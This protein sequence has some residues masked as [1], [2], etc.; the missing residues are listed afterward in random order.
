MADA[1]GQ[2]LVVINLNQQTESSDLLGGF[3]P[4]DL[5]TLCAPIRDAVE[6]LF[7]RTFSRTENAAVLD[8]L[9][10]CYA[11]QK[12]SKFIQLLKRILDKTTTLF[13][14]RDAATKT[15]DDTVS[16]NN[17]NN[18]EDETGAAKRRRRTPSPSAP[19]AIATKK[20]DD[21]KKQQKQQLKRSN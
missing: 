11:E 1:V 7:P 12:W 6:Q 19:A 20:D 9:R 4:V 15:Q 14:E 13:R 21:S 18:N 8:T 10:K 17:N 5:R 2:K 16:N 3:K